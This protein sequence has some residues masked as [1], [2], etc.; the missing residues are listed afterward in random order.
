MTLHLLLT[1]KLPYEESTDADLDDCEFADREIAAPS[2]INLSVDR[3]LERIVRRSLAL[4]PEERY[5]NAHQM[6]AD[7]EVWKPI[8][9]IAPLAAESCSSELDKAALGPLSTPDES[10]ARKLAEQAIT[11]ARFS[12]KLVDAADLMEEALTKSSG[13]REKY[14]YFVRLWRQGKVA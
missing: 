13:L 2:K 1:D 5:A 8:A 9:K 3:A 10:G 12:G 11:L 6:L 4:K 14:E 7:L